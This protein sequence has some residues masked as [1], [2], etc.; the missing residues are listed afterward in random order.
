M[1]SLLIALDKYFSSDL[2]YIIL[3]FIHGPR[4]MEFCEVCKSCRYIRYGSIY[5]DFESGDLNGRN[6]CS[7]YCFI[8]IYARLEELE[9]LMYC[10][11][12]ICPCKLNNKTNLRQRGLMHRYPITTSYII[13]DYQSAF[14]SCIRTL[15][16]DDINLEEIE[17][18]E[19]NIPNWTTC[20]A[21]V[22]SLLWK[23]TFSSDSDSYREIKANTLQGE[24]IEEL[25]CREEI[26]GVK[27][28][29]LHVLESTRYR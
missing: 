7:R 22:Y 1:S 15:F 5:D 3:M 13:E 25:M 12:S 24:G 23:Y 14:I 29:V 28:G 2:K 19:M 10:S 16:D 11:D 17:E 4:I 27:N 18:Y 26:N 8:V 21:N 9:H 6:I 20:I